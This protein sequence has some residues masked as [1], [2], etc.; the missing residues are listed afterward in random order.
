VFGSR[1][2]FASDG[3]HLAYLGADVGPSPRASDPYAA[4]GSRASVAWLLDSAAGA[5]A[6]TVGWRAP[7]E[8]T[9]QL[10]DVAW[11]PRADR[12]LVVTSQLLTG[13]VR[14]S[15]GWFVAADGQY[16]DPAF[17][18]PSDV[19]PG[20]AV[21]SPDGTHVA[22]VAHAAEVN[23]LCLLG[24]DGTFR[25]VADLDPSSSPLAFPSST[26]STDSQRMLFVAPHQRLP[27]APLDWLQADTPHAVY[28]ATLEQP[29]PIALGDTRADQVIWREDGQLLGLSR[30]AAESP[31]AV[32]LISASGGDGQELLRLP[33]T[34]GS[35]Y[36][37]VWNLARAELLVAGRNPTGSNDFWLVRLGVED[38][39]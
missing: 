15:R 17:S 1:L 21:W 27:G 34:V 32:R 11:S 25:Y 26:W 35:R 10:V 8:P 39:S 13:D 31:L 36:A 28:L 33:L 37:G 20:S 9:E 7:L 5:A 2:A 6:P 12:L 30:A 24:V 19:V 38:D 23:A 16:A 29:V 4:D 18:L 22:F 14:R 3:H